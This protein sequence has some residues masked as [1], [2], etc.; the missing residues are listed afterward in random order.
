MVLAIGKLVQGAGSAQYRFPGWTLPAFARASRFWR[1]DVAY[2][3]YMV[4]PRL[5]H[6]LP[7]HEIG[8]ALR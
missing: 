5:L 4:P 6:D 3:C 8:M 1:S 2:P 7:V